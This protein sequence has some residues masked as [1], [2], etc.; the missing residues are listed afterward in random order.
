MK[1]SPLPKPRCVECIEKNNLCISFLA[2]VGTLQDCNSGCK[3]DENCEFDRECKWTKDQGFRCKDPCQEEPCD[4]NVQC[5]VKKHQVTCDACKSGYVK[6]EEGNCVSQE[7]QK[8]EECS[9]KKTLCRF[10]QCINPCDSSRPCADNAKCRV[11]TRK[12]DGTRIKK[13][14]CP[15]HFDQSRRSDPNVGGSCQQYE[16]QDNCTCSGELCPKDISNLVCQ[17]GKC[18]GRNMFLVELQ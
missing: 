14:Y 17:N 13:C 16:C 5:V 15:K 6:N 7:C 10:G 11:E 8:D 1:E 12:G 9:D 3:D 2:R 4:E 18:T